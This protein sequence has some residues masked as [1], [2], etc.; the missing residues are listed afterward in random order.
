MTKVV[1]VRVVCVSKK[2]TQNYNFAG[3]TT[4]EIGLKLPEDQNQ[5][6]YAKDTLYMNTINKDYANMFVLGEQY[7]LTIDSL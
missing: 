1:N 5:D 7:E 3:S 4:M 6:L 2:E